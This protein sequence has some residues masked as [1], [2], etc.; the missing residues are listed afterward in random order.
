MS[1]ARPPVADRAARPKPVYGLSQRVKIRPPLP[2]SVDGR[3]PNADA[4]RSELPD[5]AWYRHYVPTW[6]PDYSIK[7]KLPVSIA[8]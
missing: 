6:I 3:R 2:V 8:T 5:V 4:G 1:L 7:V